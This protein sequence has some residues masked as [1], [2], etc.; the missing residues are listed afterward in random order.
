MS[1][2]PTLA[3][4]DA[5]DA[6]LEAADELFYRHGPAA[7]SMPQ[8]R[9]RSGVSLRRMYQLYPTKADLV[10]GWLE[11]RHHRWVDW[12]DTEIRRR[13]DDGAT[14]VDAIFDALS[15]WLVTNHFRGCGF[16]NTLAETA[17]LTEQHR[18]IIRR[19]K[20]AVIDTVTPHGPDPAALAV[21]ID[22]AIVRAAIRGDTTPI[23]DARRA[24][25]ALDSTRTQ[26]STR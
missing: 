25:S 22:G 14:A 18:E 26:G 5:R 13:Q 12:F 10:A 24:A 15:E 1:P 3:P 17:E 19:H 16:I 4:D 23:D 20:E 11:Y 21:L 2:A 7:V 6:L 8:L 9:D